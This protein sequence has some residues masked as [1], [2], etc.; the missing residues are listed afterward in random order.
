MD[1]VFSVSGS[2]F[3]SL[4][5]LRV[6]DCLLMCYVADFYDWVPEGQTSFVM[7]A[8]SAFEITEFDAWMLRDWWRKL[9]A[10]RGW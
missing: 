8:G 9:K 6:G 3:F 1:L 5:T 7:M 2:S 4:S 10:V